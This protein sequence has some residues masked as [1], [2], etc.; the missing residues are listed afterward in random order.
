MLLLFGSMLFLVALG[1]PI[2]FCIALSSFITLLFT[3]NVSLNA[4]PNLLISPINSFTL[5]AIPFYI[6][7]G[8]LLN[9][10][11]L[12]DRIIAF[13]RSLIGNIRGG[14][15]HVSVLGALMLGGVSGSMTAD[16]AAIGSV[17]IP[18]MKKAGYHNDISVS[19]AVCGSIVGAMIPPSIVMVIFAAITD[20]SIGRIFLGGIIPGIIIAIAM[21]ITSHF[22]VLKRGYTDREPFS[23]K[24]VYRTGKKAIWASLVPLVIVVGIVT[25]LTTATEAGLLAVFMAF[26]IG[27]FV[28][29]QIDSW[30]KIKKIL[31]NTATSSSLVML[32]LSFSG[33]FGELLMRMRFQDQFLEFLNAITTNPY[34]LVVI[35]V[36]FIFILGFPLDT[37]V[38]LIMFANP[39]LQ[40][41]TSFGFDP[42]H[43]A[44]IMILAS[45]ISALTPPVAVLLVL[46]CS[47]AGE[48]LERV[49]KVHTIY[50]LVILGVNILLI[51]YPPLVTWLPNK[52]MGMP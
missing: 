43:F 15:A 7:A 38:I 50:T 37:T 26:F 39:F 25:G 12:T 23:W 40:M 24:N 14:L 35:I 4:I 16:T 2:L 45:I 17:L 9:E 28:Y 1:V 41:A 8:E 42:I 48:R 33:L 47:I 34:L 51:F 6:L 31:V 27:T 32:L 52:L 19:L 18:A 30:A 29:K 22:I 44:V 3:E 49:I 21:M 11:A 5:A 36:I 20:L 10:G 13:A 46:G